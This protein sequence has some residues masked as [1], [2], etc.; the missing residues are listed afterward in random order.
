MNT[1]PDLLAKWQAAW[2]LALDCWSR[3]TQLADPRW[4]L[5]KAEVHAEGLSGSFAMIRLVDHA[6]VID[7]PQVVEHGLQDF[8]VEILA[9]EIGHHVLCP[10][11]LTDQGRL[12]TRM[13]HGLP[14]FEREAP[15]IANLYADLLIN[16]RLQRNQ[17]RDMAGIY[18]ALQQ[19]PADPEQNGLWALYLRIYEILWGLPS[20]TLAASSLPAEIEGDAQVGARLIRVYGRDW[21][22]GGGRFAC[23]C[24]RYLQTDKPL[25]GDHRIKGLH[26]LE[27][28]ARDGEPTGL[29]EIDDDEEAGNIHPSRDPDL[30]GLDPSEAQDAGSVRRD[31]GFR[32]NVQGGTKEN[33][34]FREP[35]EYGELLDSLGFHLDEEEVAIRYYRERA[36]S[37][38]IPFPVRESLSGGDPTPE[39]WEPWDIGMDINAV[40]WLKSVTGSPFIV[41]G[42]TTEQ[43][44]YAD[45]PGTER[46]REPLDLYVGIDCSGSMPNPRRQTS[47]PVLAGAIVALSCLRA[48]G[49]VMAC[50][51]GEPGRSVATRGF[52]RTEHEV[53][54][55]L[56]GYLGCGYTYGIRRLEDMLAEKRPRPVH[57]II[58][59]DN[60]IF[61]A[62]ED[63]DMSR[64]NPPHK[65]SSTGSG[66]SIAR[67]ALDQGKGGGTMVLNLSAE[68]GDTHR[69]RKEGWKVELIADWPDVVNFA[70]GFSRRLF[71]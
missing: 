59:T 6:I 49:R 35:F 13:R 38:L 57:A 63:A 3:Y 1:A 44:V 18:Q 45:G 26:D 46:T 22:A 16:D 32:A 70:R 7:L 21:L 39:G 43:Q 17:Q 56:C 65:P 34:R 31:D 54:K 42:V 69:L 8:A 52:V 10:A 66:W 15:M 37:H 71:A 41:P 24:F 20:G 4:C 62:L 23:L 11:D 48:G 47:Y 55:L 2:P 27:Q 33:K 53:L 29:A 68:H 58:L 14:G 60:D 19:T 50:L 12:L 51:S 40:D 61:A 36:A 28:A 67:H 64:L 30:T 9:H 25:N 5:S